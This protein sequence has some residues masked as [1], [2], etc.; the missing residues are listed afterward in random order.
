M[1]IGK[2]G[3]LVEQR[4]DVRRFQKRVS[5]ATEIAVTLVVRH[6]QNDVWLRRFICERTCWR[7][8]CGYQQSRKAAEDG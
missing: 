5:V 4:V 8:T 1:E 2:T 7:K 3:A 6:D